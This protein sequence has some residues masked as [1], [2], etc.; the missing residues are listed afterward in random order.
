[1]PVEVI[2]KVGMLYMIDGDVWRVCLVDDDGSAEL[3]KVNTW[4]TLSLNPNEWES[5]QR[6]NK[7]IGRY[8]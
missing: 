2:E 1:M 3:H 7:S 8:D 6:S 5:F 4:K